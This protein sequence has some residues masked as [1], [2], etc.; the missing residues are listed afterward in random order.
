MDFDEGTN[1]LLRLQKLL[2]AWR[3][4]ASATCP[5]PRS[6]CRTRNSTRL[7]RRSISCTGPLLLGNRQGPKSGKRVRLNTCLLRIPSCA[8]NNGLESHSIDD[9]N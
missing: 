6:M 5:R 7:R 4:T 1:L 8:R 2:S 3:R 9:V